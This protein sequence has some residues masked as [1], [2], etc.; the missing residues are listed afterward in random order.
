MCGLV[1]Y[2]TL[3]ARAPVVRARVRRASPSSHGSMGARE[4]NACAHSPHWAERRHRHFPRAACSAISPQFRN[5]GMML[6]PLLLLLLPPL[7][8]PPPPPPLLLL[9][10]P[11][12]LLCLFAVCALNSSITPEGGSSGHRSAA[13]G[14]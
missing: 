2:S 10:P 13:S 4:L 9:P 14:R 8:P 7:P 11:L 3:E 6:L 5:G 1:G 12:L